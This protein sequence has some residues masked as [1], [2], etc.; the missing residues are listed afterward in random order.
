MATP[1]ASAKKKI[2][3]ELKKL[4]ADGAR[5]RWRSAAGSMFGEADVDITICFYGRYIG[6]EVKRFDGKG[7]LTKRQTASLKEISDAGGDAY[8][9]DSV[10]SMNSLIA[11]MRLYHLAVRDKD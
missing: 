3:D 2:F 5:I 10:L 4:K 1:E 8:V 7:K 9:I 6:I 11:D